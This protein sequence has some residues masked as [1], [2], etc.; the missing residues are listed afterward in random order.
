MPYLTRAANELHIGWT[1]AKIGKTLRIEVKASSEH[2]AYRVQQVRRP[3]IGGRA[4]AYDVLLC[5]GVTAKTIEFW[6]VPADAVESLIGDGTFEKQHGG[7]KTGLE[8]NTYWFTMT[9]QMRRIVADYA[10]APEEL[11]KRAV[12][13]LA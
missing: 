3:R 8:S 1:P 4:F 9:P 13:L 5:L 12:A 11:R 6:L 7:K 10:A 2:P